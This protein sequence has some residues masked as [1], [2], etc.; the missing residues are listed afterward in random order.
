ML[1]SRVLKESHCCLQIDILLRLQPGKAYVYRVEWRKREFAGTYGFRRMCWN[2]DSSV[3]KSHLACK[4][5]NGML[6]L[7]ICLHLTGPFANVSETAAI[8]IG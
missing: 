3:H 1:S 7:E 4:N 6:L 5:A 2:G 8:A